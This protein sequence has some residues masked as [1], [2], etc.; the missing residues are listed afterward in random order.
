MRLDSTIPCWAGGSKRECGFPIR[1]QKRLCAGGSRDAPPEATQSPGHQI[2]TERCRRGIHGGTAGQF[3]KDAAASP[4]GPLLRES[5]TLLPLLF[6]ASLRQ[7][8]RYCR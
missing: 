4:E 5:R 6:A 8:L 1:E 7:R 3:A 2:G